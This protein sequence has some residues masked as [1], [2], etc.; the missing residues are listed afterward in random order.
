MHREAVLAT[1]FDFELATA[2][3]GSVVEEEFARLPLVD[4]VA[5]HTFAVEEKGR[6]AGRTETKGP[7]AGNVGG[8]KGGELPVQ[9]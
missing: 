1:G 6:V 4:C 3:L 5:D 8:E 7:F 2:F 9:V